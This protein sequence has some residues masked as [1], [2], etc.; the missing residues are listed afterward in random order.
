MNCTNPKAA[1]GLATGAR[2]TTQLTGGVY[3]ST[4]HAVCCDGGQ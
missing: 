4:G 2:A 3:A 1:G